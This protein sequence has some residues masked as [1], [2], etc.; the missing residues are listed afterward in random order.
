MSEVDRVLPQV[1]LVTGFLNRGIGVHHGGLLPIVK[2]CVEILFQKGLVRVLIATE[3]FAMGV[4]MPA[5]SVIF[6]SIE[7]H[8]GQKLRPLLS[9]EYTQVSRTMS[10]RK[11]SLNRTANRTIFLEKN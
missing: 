11:R 2:E 9:S 5:R 3:T 10:N 1:E 6:T 7:K 8:D 4:N